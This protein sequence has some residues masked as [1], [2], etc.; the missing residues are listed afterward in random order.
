[1]LQL[2]SVDRARVMRLAYYSLRS[3]PC[4]QQGSRSLARPRFFLW[5]C[6]SLRGFN[7]PRFA[8]LAALVLGVLPGGARADVIEVGPNGAHWIA[9]GPAG[10]PAPVPGYGP[11]LINSADPGAIPLQWQGEVAILAERYDLSPAFI[12]AVIHQESGW[13]AHALSAAGARG[14]AQLM[15]GTARLL[16]VDP[17]DPRA[18]LA[19]GAHYLRLLLDRFDGNLEK[20]LA[21]YNAG[22]GRVVAAGGVPPIA[23]TRQYVAAIMARLATAARR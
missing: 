18:N 13:Q 3:M 11:G 10:A 5:Q 12:A 8:A 7:A 22:P 4:S 21:A 6:A 23:E 17:D 15:P 2:N 20:A 14:P 9:G 16:G 19:A 1:M